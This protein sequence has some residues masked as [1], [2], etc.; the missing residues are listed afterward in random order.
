MTSPLAI[1]A[2]WSTSALGIGNEE[3]LANLLAGISPGMQELSGDIPSR[4]IWFG[5]VTAPLPEIKEPKW[6]FRS[7]QLVALAA[8]SLAGEIES[9]VA[10]YGARRIAVIL[11]ASDTG[12]DEAERYVDKWIDCGRKPDAFHFEMLELGSPA[13]FLKARLALEGPA[14]VISTACSSSAKV[15]PAAR[16]LIAAGLCDAAIVGGADSRCRFAMNGFEAL[17]ALSQGRSRPLAPDRDGINLGEAAALFIL[18]KDTA[19]AMFLFRGAGE[20]SDAYHATAPDP[21]GRGAEAAMRMA[22]EDAGLRPEDI[23]YINLHGT[24][25]VANDDMELAALSRVFGEYPQ[26]HAKAVSTKNLTGH[27]LGASGAIEAAICLDMIAGS[28]ARNALSNS[29][30][31]GG[32]NASIILS[33]S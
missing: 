14:Y 15:F 33:A 8:D 30:A 18:D 5:A 28:R 25:T 2:Y 6:K 10:K 3:T 21:E 24:G 32:S 29:F 9:I 27:T 26:A 1:R 11:G 19:N 13:E 4:S 23:D 31:F 7:C 12:V 22:L 20:T 17:G 16:R